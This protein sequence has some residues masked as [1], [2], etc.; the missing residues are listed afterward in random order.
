MNSLHLSAA[1]ERE[2]VI[3][4]V[5]SAPPEVVFGAFT[6]PDL[7]TQWLLGPPG[8]T[9]PVCQIDLMVGGAFRFVWRSPDGDEMGMGGVY[10]EVTL[11]EGAYRTHRVV[12]RRLDRRS[13]CVIRTVARTP[14]HVEPAF[15]PRPRRQRRH[16]TVRSSARS[17]AARR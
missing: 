15:R 6:K 10:R 14:S 9:M 3:K 4:P 7:V 12:R 5:F 1:G 16:D 13:F 8:W 17:P 2:T 11:P